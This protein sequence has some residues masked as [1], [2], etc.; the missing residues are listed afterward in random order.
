MP[1][2]VLHVFRLINIRENPLNWVIKRLRR[3]SNRER[4]TL[5]QTPIFSRSFSRNATTNRNCQAGNK[6]FFLITSPSFFF[7]FVLLF[8]TSM[9]I[10][11]SSC[12]KFSNFFLSFDYYMCIYIFLSF[13]VV[14][15]QLWNNIGKIYKFLRLVT[16]YRMYGMSLRKYN[17]N[18]V[19][20][21]I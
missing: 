17:Y 4:V 15:I 3:H 12:S 18:Y 13:L 5:D 2:R 1:R 10:H 20:Y 7:S 9:R 11:V 16:D 19:Y 8:L 21:I 6:V 14:L